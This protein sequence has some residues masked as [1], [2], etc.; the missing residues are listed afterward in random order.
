MA[1]GFWR[2]DLYRRRAIFHLFFRTPPFGQPYAIACGLHLAIDW[3]KQFQFSAD[4]ISYLGSLK[5]VDGKPLFELSFLN[6]L[7]R[8]NF[9]CHIDAMPEGTIVFP[10]EPLLRVEGSLIEAQLIESAL[11]NL[12]S[13]STL[14]ATKA[15]RMVEAAGDAQVIEFGLRRAQGL[16]GALTATR[17]AYI[18]GCHGTSNV[19]AGRYYGIPVSGTHAHSW[20]MIF[21]DELTAFREYARAMPNNALFLVDT[22]D[23]LAGV[24]HAITVGKELKQAGHRMLGIRLDSGD[25]GALSAEAR[26]RLDAAGFQDA[27]IVASNQI[28]EN[29]IREINQHSGQIAVWGIGTNLVTGQEQPAL[30]GV[31]KLAAVT[32]EQGNWQYRLKLSEDSAKESIPGILQVRRFHDDQSRPAGDLIYDTRLSG[33]SQGA[34]PLTGAVYSF[35]DLKG[36]DLLVPVFRD[37]NCVYTPPGIKEL[38]AFSLDQQA[39]F[40][41][42]RRETYPVGIEK[43]LNTYRGELIRKYEK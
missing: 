3:L 34:H 28:D 11:L 42:I 21:D 9:S 41:P 37:G 14:I 35:D 24:E 31:Y 12:I 18:G 6:Y 2:R 10:Y 40:R 8:L 25:L 27:V 30:G 39:L 13:F 32:D 36:K 15:S 26:R 33:T 20:V 4:D 7:Q 22:Y 5:G 23:S 43:Q 19:A 38:R 16:D 29:R 17:S 1:N